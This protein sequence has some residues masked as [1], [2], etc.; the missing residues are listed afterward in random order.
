MVTSCAGRILAVNPSAASPIPEDRGEPSLRHAAGQKAAD[1]N[2]ERVFDRPH[3]GPAGAIWH[4]D[5][6]IVGHV[7]PSALEPD[8]I[9]T[10]LGFP[11]DVGNDGAIG[12]RA[13]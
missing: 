8:A 10:V 3:H 4:G 9:M 11:I 12:V 6:G 2:P 1:R 7:D 13:A 5:D